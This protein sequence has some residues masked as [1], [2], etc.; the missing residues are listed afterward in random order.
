MQ[1]DRLHLFI[2]KYLD[3][4]N[5]GSECFDELIVEAVGDYMAE[6]MEQSF[7]PYPQLDHVEE[8]LMEECW[9]ILRKITYGSLTLEDYREGRK[10]RDRKKVD[11]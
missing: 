10:K 2:R 4:P 11:C 7:I 8:I 1:N 9:D 5:S 6:L 3:A